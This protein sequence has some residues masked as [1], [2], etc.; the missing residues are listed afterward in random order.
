[1]AQ[2]FIYDALDVNV[3]IDGVIATMFGEGSMVS[4]ARNE[5][6][7]TAHFGV[8][9]EYGTSVNNN[10]SGTI[11][12][13]FQQGSPA[14][15]QLQAL[16]NS[17]RSFP[18][19]VVDASARGGFRAGGNEAMIITEPS[20]DRNDTMTDRTWDIFVFDYSTVGTS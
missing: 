7:V 8:K 6:R 20:N 2:N 15:R 3:I 4:C 12:V 17:K 19:S 9:G 1:M 16:A 18:I 13:T 5:D 11:S 10:N 14:N